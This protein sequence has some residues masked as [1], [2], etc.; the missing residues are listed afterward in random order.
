M[1]FTKEEEREL[2]KRVNEK[3]GTASQLVMVIEECSELITEVSKNLRFPYGLS[4]GLLKEGV[5]VQ[6]MINQLKTILPQDE[7][8]EMYSYKLKRLQS[9]LEGKQ[10]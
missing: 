9:R 3:W 7:W 10:I 6:I 1:V 4:L 5:D 2:Y 8:D